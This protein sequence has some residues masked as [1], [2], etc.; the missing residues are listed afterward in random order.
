MT[1]TVDTG[2]SIEP[3][4]EQSSRGFVIGLALIALAGL[5][6][7]IGAAYFY[8]AH[9]RIGGDAVWYTGVAW[10]LAHGN[11][12]IEPLQFV[13]FGHRVPT[14]AHPPLYPF[15]LLPVDLV[16][17]DSVLLHRLWSC[18]PGTGTVVLLGFIGRDLAGR[19][20]GLI[21]AALAAVSIE[22]F[23][24]D[25]LLWSEGL[26]GFT[27]ALT[28]FTAYRY[29]RRPDRLHAGLL[30]GAIA[31]ASLTRAE[32]V[33]LFLILFVPLVLRNR[34]ETWGRRFATVGIG[35]VVAIVMIGPWLV[36]NN[37]GRFEKPV[38]VTVTFGTLIGSSNCHATYYG[39][40]VGA[41]GG[42]CA[43]TVPNPW[44]RDESLAEAAARRAGFQ[45]I[46]DHLDRLPVVVAA[47]LGR[48]FGF[49]APTKTISDD[50]ALEQAKEHRVVYVAIV[51]YWLYLALG[52]AGAVVLSRRRTALLPL[53]APVLTVVAITIIG[54]GTMRFRLALDVVL[55]VLA[56]VAVDGLLARRSW[57]RD[58]AAPA[59]TVASD[60]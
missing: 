9:T 17:G 44:P 10:N 34:A 57:T 42:L 49:Y 18:L 38:G 32:A 7:R 27:V 13:A 28:V 33:F 52:V 55:P 19:R 29:L 53:L 23:A 41:W 47:R 56:A 48:S 51:Q 2:A 37:S 59:G 4:V 50:L 36:Y 24:Q 35:A 8:D 14:A 60:S 1:T 25:V 39:A 31:L 46:S 22:L 26:Y 6:L 15:F 12:F 40:G 20:A 30:A 16:F 21:A 43:D 54:Y 11:G 45:Y 5:A 3:P 58:P